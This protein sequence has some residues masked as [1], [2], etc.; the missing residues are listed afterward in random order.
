VNAYECPNDLYF[1][2]DLGWDDD[3]WENFTAD[4]AWTN[5]TEDDDTF[6]DGDDQS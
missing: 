2:P 4:D 1:G 6:V 3:A 5:F